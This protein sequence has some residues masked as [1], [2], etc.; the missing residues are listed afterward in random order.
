MPYL[1]LSCFHYKNLNLCHFL[2]R[3]ITYRGEKGISILESHFKTSQYR[4]NQLAQTERL[5][6][7][8]IEMAKCV[9]QWSTRSRAEGPTNGR[10]INLGRCVHYPLI[11]KDAVFRW[12]N[13]FGVIFLEGRRD[14]SRYPLLQDK[15]ST[16]LLEDKHF[17]A[18]KLWLKYKAARGIR[19]HPFEWNSYL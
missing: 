18:G 17:S 10:S 2:W 16:S 1:V 13:A 9:Y 14:V 15:I 7:S 12:H 19:L 8:F 5:G 3:G 4:R 6:V 11:S